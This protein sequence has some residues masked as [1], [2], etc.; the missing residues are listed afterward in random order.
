VICTS[1]LIINHFSG[2]HFVVF[3]I[4]C[5]SAVH[6]QLHIGPLTTIGEI[7]RLIHAKFKGTSMPVDATVA[8]FMPAEWLGEGSTH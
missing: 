5:I 7:K 2:I 3:S 6:M 4:K 1:S 8:E